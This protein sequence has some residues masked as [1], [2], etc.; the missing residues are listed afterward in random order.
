MSSEYRKTIPGFEGSTGLR[1]LIVSS[2]GLDN[3]NDTRWL[4]FLQQ[5]NVNFIEVRFKVIGKTNT[6][7]SHSGIVWN[8]GHKTWYVFLRDRGLS[9]YISTTAVSLY[10]AQGVLA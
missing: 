9:D 3:L 4:L 6:A 1:N 2:G 8:D 5:H 10:S 7:D